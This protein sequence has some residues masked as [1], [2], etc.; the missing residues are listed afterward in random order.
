MTTLF[1]RFSTE[2]STE[3]KLQNDEVTWMELS[4]EF[5]AFLQGCGYQMTRDEFAE[6][7]MQYS[8]PEDLGGLD[9]WKGQDITITT[10]PC[11]T[12]PFTTMYNEQDLASNSYTSDTITIKL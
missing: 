8:E 11:S 12:S 10:T 3:V 4:E 6:Y 7:W 2:R 5:F 1:A 9:E